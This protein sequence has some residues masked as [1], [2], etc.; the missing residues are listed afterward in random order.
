M[1]S[2]TGARLIDAFCA[3]SI[4]MSRPL[5]LCKGA[6]R[7]LSP[8]TTPDPSCSLTTFFHGFCE[9]YLPGCIVSLTVAVVWQSEWPWRPRRVVRP[10]CTVGLPYIFLYWDLTL[11]HRR[12]FGGPLGPRVGRAPARSYDEYLKAYSVAM[13]PGRERENLSYGGKSMSAGSRLSTYPSCHPPTSCHA[14][15]CTGPSHKLGP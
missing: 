8:T 11:D 15:F 3:F 6:L 10:A 14:T 2:T 1:V 7:M 5:P 9:R 13:L 4:W 12:G